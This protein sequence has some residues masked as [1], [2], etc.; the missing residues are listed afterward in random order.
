MSPLDGSTGPRAEPKRRAAPQGRPAAR[1]ELGLPMRS[2]DHRP[3][4]ALMAN[5]W[6]RPFAEALPR[7]H[8]VPD[9]A[10][11]AE[12]LAAALPDPVLRAHAVVS[13]NGRTLP[14]A[15]WGRVRPKA[16]AVLNIAVRP[17]GGDDGNKVL[18]TILQIAVVAVAT[19]VGGGAGGAIA[20]KFWAAVA[21]ASVAIAGNLAI[22]ALV[23]PPQLE[24]ESD[25]FSPS[26]TIEAARNEIDPYG[27]VS[28]VFGKR[29]IFP[30][31]QAAPL[32]ETVGDDVYLR[33]LFSLGPMPLQISGLKIGETALSEFEGVE[34]EARLKP[35]DPPLTLFANDPF[36]ESVGAHLTQG[37]W[38]TRTT[39]PDCGEIVAVLGFPQGLG[40]KDKKGKNVTASVTVEMAYQPIDADPVSDPWYG[41]RA[42]AP[43][44]N[45]GMDALG[46]V[47]GEGAAFG[48]FDELAAEL[49]QTAPVG[50]VT[51]SRAEAGKPFRRELRAAVPIGQYR[52][53]VRRVDAEAD[54]DRTAD[55][56]EFQQLISISPKDPSPEPEHAVLAM[57]I[58]AS[59]QLSGVVD[60]FNCVAE[61]IAKGLTTALLEA[62][63][64]DLYGVG[65]PDFTAARVTRNCADQ[66]LF[67]LQGP[68]VANPAPDSRINWRSLAA[69][70]RWCHQKGY[71]FDEVITRPMRRADLLR[72]ICAAGR[73][74]PVKINGQ[75]H[76]IVDGPR[77]G[78]PVQMFTARNVNGLRVSRTFP[79]D[80]HALRCEF[81]NEE[82]DYRTDERIVYFE[83]YSKDGAAPGTVEATNIEKLDLPGCTNP[84]I[85]YELL[86][87]HGA[88]ALAQT[89]RYSWNTDIEGL[90]CALGS[91][92]ALQHPVMLVAL[93]AARVVAAIT[94]PGT[95]AVTGLE[96]DAPFEMR[97]GVDYGVRWRRV[98]DLGDGAGE[99]RVED[100]RAI[101]TDPGLQ[102]EIAFAEPIPAGADYAPE[103]EDLVAFGEFGQEAVHAIV[104][105][106]RP[107]PEL[108]AALEAVIEAPERYDAGEGPI[109]AFTSAI[110]TSPPRRPP[111][112]TLAAV[113]V[114]SDGIFVGFALPAGAEARVARIEA[115]WRQ[116]P[117][118]GAAA[119]WAPLAALSPADRVLA[120]TPP[121]P[122]ADY[123]FRVELVDAAGRRSDPPLL[124]TA[125][126]ADDALA[127]PEGVQALGVTRESANG[128][129]Q[130]ALQIAATPDEDLTLTDLLVE[131]RPS[132]SDEDA[133]FE[134]LAVLP[135]DR[136]NRDVRDV[137]PGATVDV[138]FRY[139]ARRGERLVYSPYAIVED[140]EIPG[141]VVASDAAA[142]TAALDAARDAVNEARGRA[143][144]LLDEADRTLA[145]AVGRAAEDAQLGAQLSLLNRLEDPEFTTGVAGWDAVKGAV[146]PIAGT[147]GGLQ[148]VWQFADAGRPADK[149]LQWPVKWP[150]NEGR[151]VQAGVETGLI[152]AGGEI[153][154]EAVWLDAA[155]D[156]VSVSEIDRGVQGRLA[157]V[158]EA[159]AGAVEV[160]IRM[161]PVAA[162]AG[163]GGFAIRRPLAASALPGQ[164]AA[165]SY[166]APQNEMVARLAKLE[167]IVGQMAERER[168][169][170]VETRRG[171]AVARENTQAIVDETQARVNDFTTFEAAFNGR[172]DDAEDDIAA[173][174]TI[175][176]VNSVQAG[177]QSAI[178][179]TAATLQSQ[180]QAGD[181][182]LSTAL[183]NS[184][185]QAI[186]TATQARIESEDQIRADYTAAD[187]VVSSALTDA[188][189]LAIASATQSRVQ[190]ENQIRTDFT[191]ADDAVSTALSLQITE[192]VS[193]EEQA[194]LTA[195]TVIRA[196]FTAADSAL[197][198]ALTN[199]YT[200]A[201]ATETQARTL[202]VD[203]VVADFTAADAALQVQIDTKA[204]Y[205]FVVDAVASEAAARTTVVEET[206]AEYR[207]SAVPPGMGAVGALGDLT[208]AKNA[209]AG[210]IDV[211]G[212]FFDHPTLGRLTV[213]L[214]GLL[215]TPFEGSTAPEGERFFLMYSLQSLQARFNSNFQANRNIVP[216][217]Y[218]WSTGQWYAWPNTGSRVA[219]TPLATDVI[220]AAA[221]KRA[222]ASNMG[223]ITSFVSAAGPINTTIESKAS[224]TELT[225]AMASAA[226]ARTVLQQQLEAE[227]DGVNANVQ[228]NA[229]A[230]SEIEG[231]L[232]AAYG[233]ILDA[234]GNIASMQGL[235][236]GSLTSWRF[237][238][239]TFEIFN[240][241]T[242]VAPF[243]V[244]GG[245]VEIQN[246]RIHGGLIENATLSGVKLVDATVGAEKIPLRAITAPNAATTTTFGPWAVGEYANL[247]NVRGWALQHLV[248]PL[249]DV[250]PGA[251]LKAFWDYRFSFQ[252][253][254]AQFIT[255]WEAVYLIKT[256]A[257]LPGYRQ[258]AGL[259][260]DEPLLCEEPCGDVNSGG[261]SP[262]IINA[263]KW[264]SRPYSGSAD[265]VIP[266]DATGSNY[267][268]V[269][270]L[271]LDRNEVD[272]SNG[273]QN[274]I[275]NPNG[276]LQY[277]FRS[278]DL[279]AVSL[280]R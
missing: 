106:L 250:I 31:L 83:G 137:P 176:F 67:A 261:L 246:V 198:T 141:E 117:A 139:R 97:A 111:S 79:A 208:F 220:L 186:A 154:L 201:L 142:P 10:R 84:A 162:E 210:E 204:E 147:P 114:T 62:D 60:T 19:W 149:Y 45:A 76:F 107:G 23:P 54:D 159:P 135:P 133:D 81:P 41:A 203:Q 85:V 185:M 65:A 2:E 270:T 88:T 6:D 217:E 89:E 146:L 99:I 55:R 256:T 169:L 132:A 207:K 125:I 91:R 66:A 7:L 180:Y 8:P 49:A 263:N 148:V 120:F 175:S 194:R 37:A 160:T 247:G 212:S 189:T 231:N 36:T 16:G 202:Q 219:F 236:T 35:Q 222:A 183:T 190:A 144:E 43:Q 109:P 233:I 38:V 34:W 213:G 18:R 268:L 140:V 33:L 40:G 57:R 93:G 273:N 181:S 145:Y 237:R 110:V 196:D 214:T 102:R 64:P 126:S 251:R 98:V 104:K 95:G 127:A 105:K 227:I 48:L 279:H 280:K 197:S 245:V 25:R 218:A 200:Q 73:A 26:Y 20:S 115:A 86:R 5:V 191:A 255:W 13:L 192:A 234:N 118:E 166:T 17:A 136:P 124:V 87:F 254:C 249:T 70:A 193:D 173:R 72:M 90:T 74:R 253:K 163:F 269:L 209:D 211:A 188:Y 128:V 75:Y 226:A 12:I 112:P 235:A 42:T 161:A 119:S 22:N 215:V 24:L 195:Q 3:K 252:G 184:Y 216:V 80:V 69:F 228:I 68:M 174:A 243:A 171:R 103:A 229:A 50:A 152:G 168:S 1:S 56:A 272:H 155:G 27:P 52:V 244:S 4:A 172:L 143:T 230:I 278:C 53:R 46:A 259:I 123:D 29:R 267:R 165:D 241:S 225:D 158:V 47:R 264:L 101:I 240:G 78:P 182:A 177:L 167:R 257:P 232:V 239:D 274:G 150:V 71:T 116:T 122:A 21:G 276:S 223:T 108:S 58:K 178:S 151:F 32:Q 179:S 100:S 271:V 14:E 96:L 170:Q 138:G 11:V 206:R 39:Q 44:A 121:D 260:V 275:L 238:S 153:V 30:K 134:P 156:A 113:N 82:Q 130:P 77:E 242:G 221:E 15:C 277:A 248:C 265:I 266:G 199:A 164:D 205:T 224:Y 51:Y 63:E 157:G 129:R 131:I 61:R 9:G 258:T 187:N 59:D 94:D 92:I 262:T 28:L